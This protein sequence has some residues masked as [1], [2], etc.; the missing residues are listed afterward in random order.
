MSKLEKEFEVVITRMHHT[1]E[2]VGRYKNRSIFVF[3]AIM[4]ERALVRPIKVSRNKAKAAIIELLETSP[5]RRDAREGHYMSCSPWQIISYPRQL[6]YKIDMAKTLFKNEAGFVPDE[7]VDIIEPEKEWHYRNKMEFS[8]AEKGNGDL[9][10][11]FHIRN[12]RYD[13]CR[14]HECALAHYK[15]NEVANEVVAI[16]N[17][18]QVKLAQLKNIVVRYSYREAKCLVVLY[19][20]DENFKPFDISITEAAGWQIIYS[21]PQS[22]A[23]VITKVLH[24]QGRD[25]LEEKIDFLKLRYRHNSFF[26]TNP[27]IFRELLLFVRDNIKKRGDLI[28]L[29]AGVGTIGMFLAKNFENVI[30]VELDEEAVKTAKENIEL[31]DLKNVTFHLGAT[32]KQDLKGIFSM[33]ETLVVDPPRS[34][35]HP[36]VTK[37]ILN[38][39][40]KQFVYVSC[41]PLTQAKDLSLLKKKYKVKQWR[42]FDLYPQTPHVESV[43]ILR[44]KIFGWF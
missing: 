29:Y 17:R 5:N 6:D 11:A 1:G 41:N 19:V 14:I 28:D 7:E 18:H 20:K 15:I 25:Y 37:A 34:G 44:R 35:L 21:D 22:P 16:M 36:K 3:G 10:L 9:A 23:T 2:G 38:S 4:G 33:A 40:I 32:E 13:C 31:N 43:L 26:Q 24:Q 42:L 12:R 27:P 39:K 30:A 8:F